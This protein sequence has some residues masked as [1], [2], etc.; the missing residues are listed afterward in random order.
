MKRHITRAIVL[1]RINYAEADRII[2]VLTPDLGKIAAMAKGVR[3][4]RS[5][6]A[7]GIEL[8]SISEVGLIQGKS[9]MYTLSTTRLVTHFDHI[10][11]NV[12]H[13]MYG[14]EVLKMVDKLTEDGA[15]SSYFNLLT[16]VLT[17]LNTEA[18]NLALLQIWVN[19][20]LMNMNGQLPN[21]ETDNTG[22]KLE[23]NKTYEFDHEAMTF[24]SM[25]NGNFQASHIKLLRLAAIQPA[26]KMQRVHLTHNV[27]Q[28]T[29]QLT[30]TIRKQRFN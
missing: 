16:E 6:L 5:K 21:L 12:D 27:S 25:Q 28:T 15:D 14:Y 18:T 3:K 2:T 9:D 24:Q 29:L 26:A 7:G 30:E 4:E 1:R 20:Q 8:F 17:V 23:A 13:T 22:N 11:R 19:V 10:V